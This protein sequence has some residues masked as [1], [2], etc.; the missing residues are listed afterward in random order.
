[1]T[2]ISIFIHGLL[3]ASQPDSDKIE[4]Q[5]KFKFRTI[6][7]PIHFHKRFNFCHTLG[8]KCC[9]NLLIILEV[10][11]EHISDLLTQHRLYNFQFLSDAVYNQNLLQFC[12]KYLHIFHKVWN[13]FLAGGE[14]GAS[15]REHGE[16]PVKL[17][18]SWDIN[19][20]TLVLGE[21][22]PPRP[23]PP[24]IPRHHVSFTII[25]L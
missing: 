23:F 25:Y 11:L 20:V 7:I 24:N 13:K 17:R 16:F 1:M 3:T 5:T 8:Q 2:L 14:G 21:I 15:D 6:S 12:A 19:L 10:I 22:L 9:Q 4:F 18:Q